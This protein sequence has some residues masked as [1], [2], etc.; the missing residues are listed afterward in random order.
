MEADYQRF[1]FHDSLVQLGLLWR[2][3]EL[4]FGIG[5]ARHINP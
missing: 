4:G 1:G 5:Y 2:R 3:A